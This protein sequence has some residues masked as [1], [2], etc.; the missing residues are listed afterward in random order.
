V[1]TSFRVSHA[2]PRSAT[3]TA[4]FNIRDDGQDVLQLL[5]PKL[6]FIWG[7]RVS[8]LAPSSLEHQL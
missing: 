6:D 7:D 4:P 5:L 1:I 2:V 8:S 3:T